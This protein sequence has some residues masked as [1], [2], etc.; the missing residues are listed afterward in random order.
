MVAVLVSIP[1]KRESISERAAWRVNGSRRVVYVSI[2]FKRESISEPC[3]IEFDLAPAIMLVSIPFKRESISERRRPVLDRHRG[4]HFGFNS[5]QTGKHIWTKSITHSALCMLSVSIPFK[6]ESISEQKGDKNEKHH[7]ERVSIPFKRESISEL[8]WRTTKERRHA[9]KFQFPSNGKAYLNGK[10][11]EIFPVRDR[12]S[13]NSLQTGKHIWTPAMLVS[14]KLTQNRFNS[15]QT[16]KHIWTHS[17]S[18][19]CQ[20]QSRVCFNSLQTGK[21]IWTFQKW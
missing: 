17:H 5:L 19:L 14:G 4:P 15:L 7:Y 3:W 1:F 20:P 9:G 11:F 18:H 13:F 16:G 6:R 21:H 10:N 12:N 8:C 2:P